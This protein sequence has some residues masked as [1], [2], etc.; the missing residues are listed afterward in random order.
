MK[1]IHI[2]GTDIA[3]RSFA[4]H[5]INKRGKEVFKKKCN[6]KQLKLLIPKLEPC[7]VAMETCGGAHYW[8][9]EFQK[10]GFE[11]R[12]ISPKYVK[13]YLAKVNK[14]VPNDAQAIAEAATR[15]HLNFV[16]VKQIWQNEI[17]FAHRARSKLIRDRTG[18][19]NQIHGF[20]HEIGA[21]LSVGKRAIEKQLPIVL[22]VDEGYEMSSLM[23]TVL[24]RQL[25]ALKKLDDEIAFYDGVLIQMSVAIEPCSR[26]KQI[27]GVGP[28]TA[29]AVVGAMGDPRNYKSGRQFSAWLGLVPKQYSSGGR[30]RLLG[31][32]KH[33]DRY[34]RYLLIHGARAC[35][36]HSKNRTDRMSEWVTKK[37]EERGHNRATAALANKNARIIWAMLAK[38]REFNERFYEDEQFEV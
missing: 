10:R 22:E 31:I 4:L 23:R 38:G 36:R 7:I 24:R 34:L 28:L 30:E 11:V 14:N 17:Q 13:A 26:I 12:L 2:L 1:N 8:G 5:G 25:E 18:L 3:K 37:T 19:V 15:P 6:R 21:V 16:P 32:S 35:L 29:T 33:G 20:L 9:R 27:P